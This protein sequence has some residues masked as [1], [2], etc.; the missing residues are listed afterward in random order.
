MSSSNRFR[1]LWLFLFFSAFYSGQTAAISQ[2]KPLLFHNLSAQVNQSILF[3]RLKDQKILYQ[4]T[5]QALLIPASV[6]KL[7]TSGASLFHLGPQYKFRTQFYHTGNRKGHMIKG[8]LIVV[9]SGDPLFIS[10]KLWQAAA[11]LRHMG[12]R[13]ISGDIIIDNSLFDNETMLP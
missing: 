4:K 3:V 6:T 1:S 13:S 7:V 9:G 2:P 10:E 5:P 8:D 12:I 11:D